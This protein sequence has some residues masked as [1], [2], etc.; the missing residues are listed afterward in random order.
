MT[1]RDIITFLYHFMS[2]DRNGST[3]MLQHR[4]IVNIKEM[5]RALLAHHRYHFGQA[6]STKLTVSLLKELIGYT[7]EGP[8]AK[9]LKAGIAK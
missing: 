8:L 5:N 6:Q 4:Q 1:Q 3:K 9:Q 2:D 7:A